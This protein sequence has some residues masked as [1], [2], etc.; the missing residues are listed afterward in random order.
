MATFDA[1]HQCEWRERAEELERENRALKE[2][3]GTIE[4]QLALLQRT[5]F[6]RKSEKLPRVEDELRKASGNAPRPREATLKERRL[7]REAREALPERLIHHRVPEEARRCPSCGGMALKPLGPGTRTEL[8]EHVPAHVE[9]QVH[10]QETLAC[11]CGAGI[12]T[13]PAPKAIEQGKYGPGFLAHV[14]TAKCCDS[15]PLYRQA[16]ALARAGVPVARTT[17]CDVFHEVGWATAPLASRLLDLVRESSR[18]NADETPQRVL[19]EGKTRRAYV[20][21]FRTDEL[22]AYVHSASRSGVTPLEVLGGTQGYLQVDGYTGYNRVT[23]PDGRV[24]VGC[25]AHVRRKFFDALPTAPESG[26]ALDFIL[27]L[28]GVEH[29]AR[30]SETLGS[31]EHLHARRTTSARVLEQLATWVDEQLPLH[32]PKSPLGMALRYTKGQWSALTRFLED[33]SL[34]LDNNAAERALRGM[35]MGRK[36]YLFVGNDKAGQTLAG[37]ASLVATCEANGV[38]PEAYLADV[39][40]RLGS[41]PAARLDELL[42]HRWRPSSASS[43]DS[44]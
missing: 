17:L 24:R 2:R 15:I 18:V 10:L 38:N 20:W 4:S 39:L 42:P 43:P 28:Y 7:K 41:H 11:P 25:W 32:P 5:V 6:G 40:M 14:V 8:F 30:D 36:N 44:S 9:R 21:T 29:A 12:V 34:P 1:T 13:A 19:D 26:T 37:L 3:V 27:A 33:P 31:P 16:K 22:I 23:L 35:A